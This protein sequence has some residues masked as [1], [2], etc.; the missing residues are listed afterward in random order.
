MQLEHLAEVVRD[1][2]QELSDVRE[3]LVK[4]EAERD[5]AVRTGETEARLLRE[6]LERERLRADS[7][8][9]ELRDLHRPWWQRLLGKYSV[10][11]SL[12]S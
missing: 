7:L 6:V 4:A 3:R 9:Q 8:A 10:Q 11:A 1:L 12:P 2:E 5:A